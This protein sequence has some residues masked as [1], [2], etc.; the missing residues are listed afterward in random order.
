MSIPPSE[1][2]SDTKSD[3]R[4][5]Y[6]KNR[7]AKKVH[8]S[9]QLRRLETLRHR[10]IDN[11]VDMR[12]NKAPVDEIDDFVNQLDELN[13]KLKS[14]R[15]IAHG[16]NISEFPMLQQLREILQLLQDSAIELPSGVLPKEDLLK[17]LSSV[18][19]ALY[20]INNDRSCLT[21]SINITNVL[22][23]HLPYDKVQAFM[24]LLCDSS[25]VVYDKFRKVVSQSDDGTVEQE[26]RNMSQKIWSFLTGMTDVVND[27][28]V[29]QVEE[30]CI[31]ISA[32]FYSVRSYCDFEQLDI[33]T[34]L[35][36]FRDLKKLSNDTTSVVDS[37]MSA[38]MFVVVHWK[39]LVSGD[40]S[41]VFLGKDT[42]EAFEKEVQLL[43]Q[44]YTFVVSGRAEELKSQYGRTEKQFEEALAE[45]IKRCDLLTKQ[46][47]SVNQR[48]T[49][50]RYIS[51]LR[52]LETSIY[53]MKAGS[54]E[55]KQP[56][57]LLLSGPSKTGKSTLVN[58]L[59]AVILNEFGHAYDN[60][61]VTT[62]NID[63][64]FESTV[65]PHHKI[66][67]CDD[68]A[69]S[70]NL[71]PNFDRIL[72]YINTVP[73]SLEKA[74]VHEKGCKYPMNDAC[75]VTTNVP[76][77][78]VMEHS[79]CPESILRRFG[80]HVEVKIAEAFSTPSG[81]IV[82]MDETRFDIYELTLKRFSEIDP[83]CK[84]AKGILYDVIPFEEWNPSGD[85]K[86]DIAC[87]LQYLRKDLRAHNQRQAKRAVMQRELRKGE[88]CDSCKNPKV[89]CACGCKA[90]KEDVVVAE[91]AAEVLAYATEK[92]WKIRNVTTSGGLSLWNN[93]S[94]GLMTMQFMSY[95][96]H[97]RSYFRNIVIGSLLVSIL[98]GLKTLQTGN[99]IYVTLLFYSFPL[100]VGYLMYSVRKE[101][102]QIIATRKDA[103]SSICHSMKSYCK[104]HSK[105]ALVLVTSIYFLYR[106]Y[107][108]V[109]PNTQDTS[110]Y[111]PKATEIFEKVIPGPDTKYYRPSVDGEFEDGYT[112]L[113][114]HLIGPSAT[115]TSND[116]QMMMAKA[117]RLVTVKTKGGYLQNIQGLI[118]KGNVLLVP[119]HVL[120]QTRPF[121]VETTTSPGMPSAV[122]KDQNLGDEHIEFI[123]RKDLVCIHL[124]SAPAA[125]D[126]TPF[127]PEE[128][129]NFDSRPTVL[130]GKTNQNKVITSRQAI[131]PHYNGWGKRE[132][133]YV[134][135]DEKNGFLYG[136]RNVTTEITIFNPY[137]AEL[138]FNSYS[139]LCGAMYVD[140][141]KAIIYGMHVAGYEKG[142][143]Q[144][145]LTTV[146]RCDI[147]KAIAALDQKSP[148]MVL[149]S[150]SELRLNT[151]GTDYTV[152]NS[153][154]LYMLDGGNKEKSIVTFHG[155]VLKD[156]QEMVESARTPYMKTPFTGIQ[157]VFGTANSIPPKFP[158]SI[159]KGLKT[160][161][162]LT[163]PVQHY[164]HDTLLRA[165]DDFS[166][167]VVKAVKDNLAEAQTLIRMYS[168]Q[169]AMD[170]VGAAGFKGIPN[171]T[172][173][174][175]PYNCSKR[176]VLKSDPMDPSLP[177]T[178][179]EFD[180][181]TY[182]VQKDVDEIFSL[183]EKGLRSET[184]FKASSKTNELLPRA[185]AE[186]KVRKFYGSNMAFLVNARRV[187]SGLVLFM[188]NH[189]E[190]FECFVGIN[191]V[192]NDWTEFH[193]YI[194]RFGGQRMIAGDFSGFDTTMAQQVSTSAARIIV[195]IYRAAGVAEEDIVILKACLSDICN[196]NVLFMGNLY[197]FANMNPSGQP[198]TVQLNSIV[199]SIMM[200][201]VYYKIYPES[202]TPLSTHVSLATFGDDN[203][204]DVARTAP[205]FTHTNCQRE[206]E[207][208]GIGYTMADKGAE[209][210]PYITI[211]EA[212][213]LKR[214]FK[215]LD[216]ISG[217][218]AP[219]EEESI[220]KK[221]H[222]CKKPNSSPLPPQE[223]FAWHCGDAFVEAYLHGRVYYD[224]FVKKI[225]M[226]IDQNEI[227]QHR[228]AFLT[229][230]E[231]TNKL[232]QYYSSDYK[233]GDPFMFAESEEIYCSW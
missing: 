120:P 17:I 171:K 104:E 114:P 37:L 79:N 26:D 139:G 215:K 203:L 84:G 39:Q 196:P 54:P 217:I 147:N 186:S 83:T 61:M 194:T 16:F 112:R 50:Q 135:K 14:Q 140:V 48:I 95:L 211:D 123:P 15:I 75:I 106:L 124:P 110:T 101:V 187:L 76:H 8:D 161:N 197:N 100:F 56:Y 5:K 213:F 109:R 1:L 164:E 138:E 208:I 36:K 166:N 78:N 53:L 154:P 170:G 7:K 97:H 33:K 149:A 87:L 173:A 107:K 216:H 159:E 94:S 210:R 163:A 44:Q 151:E 128:E 122:T 142:S 143:P 34:A 77:L 209:S 52:D 55:R 42:A 224:E 117:L 116:L 218:G 24:E 176:K 228:V 226:V 68:V 184:I 133:K 9:R 51:E 207:K 30:F 126:Y 155:A 172:S 22:V 125:K 90:T 43:R 195:D 41:C 28:R 201:Y 89:V 130:V 88:M 205:K 183:W 98:M 231:M 27:M 119:A 132:L 19:T 93:M 6:N 192:S 18:I 86:N 134:G 229:Y 20:N 199:N 162:K 72:N 220:I 3:N 64:K 115:T 158:N 146:N 175:H 46:A 57:G 188:R 200:R 198:I 150:R 23:Q 160:L 189:S 230:Q 214:G 65:E 204:M 221:F 25:G 156:G 129:I 58:Q 174:G 118:V 181:S 40:W 74:G 148:Q 131:K 190:E 219:I 66:I 222:Y 182:D 11:I 62:A 232:S 141:D 32:L 49:L 202:C 233:G 63:E 225:T 29:Q 185:K 10:V 12:A 47:S 212:S 227:L 177:L 179:R 70:A 81:G 168:Q 35:K 91:S 223:Q 145:F 45:C 102:D 113:P 165:T 73:R 105:Q 31:K 103:L 96:Y 92:L 80:L 69:N 121:D 108:A 21:L 2:V 127:F 38:Y 4:R 13:K 193:K 206:F 60:G 191:P 67:V 99:M 157:E 71:R 153:K 136:V 167:Q 137:S 169:E 85:H 59:C 180:D 82:D 144:G 152:V 111:L 178:P